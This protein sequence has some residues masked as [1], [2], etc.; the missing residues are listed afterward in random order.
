[1][2][3]VCSILTN[4][5]LTWTPLAKALKESTDLHRALDNNFLTQR[6]A[7]IGFNIEFTNA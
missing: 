6:V 4:R 3:S 5:T 1:V 2:P 7:D